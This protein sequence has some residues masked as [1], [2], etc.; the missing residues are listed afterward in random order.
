MAA[1]LP[2]RFEPF[3][4][5]APQRAL[6]SCP[7]RDTPAPAAT[8]HGILT[9]Y[10][11]ARASHIPERSSVVFASSTCS[12]KAGRAADPRGKDQVEGTKPHPRDRKGKRQGRG[13]GDG[14][15]HP[16]TWGCVPGQGD[17]VSSSPGKTA[18][19]LRASAIH[20]KERITVDRH[21][22]PDPGGSARVPA[23]PNQGAL[24]RAR[25]VM[26]GVVEEDRGRSS[27]TAPRR[28]MVMASAAFSTSAQ[29]RARG[30]ETEGDYALL[31]EGLVRVR[32]KR[33]ACWT[34][35]RERGHSGLRAQRLHQITHTSSVHGGGGGAQRGNVL[36]KNLGGCASAKGRLRGASPEDARWTRRWLRTSTSSARSAAE[37]HRDA[38]NELSTRSCC[39]EAHPGRRHE[40]SI[41]RAFREPLRGDSG[42][43]GAR[44]P[45]GAALRLTAGPVEPA[46]CRDGRPPPRQS[47]ARPRLAR[48]AAGEIVCGRLQ[49]IVAR[50][51]RA[52]PDGRA[53]R[54]PG[55]KHHRSGEPTSLSAAD[56]P[57]GGRELRWRTSP[58]RGAPPSLGGTGRTAALTTAFRGNGSRRRA[59]QRREAMARVTRCRL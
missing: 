43:S 59:D 24:Q 51:R 29:E 23:P 20:D 28:Q 21:P 25:L 32:G 57:R 17:R 37:R 41:V 56:Y 13:S 53:R 52:S 16:G 2:R 12:T 26:E 45:I 55:H 30:R 27:T 18:P 14:R 58:D 4:S 3:S 31:A 47:S 11:G 46:S 6:P 1:T 22:G 49:A 39:R 5:R 34:G 38:L 10:R 15:A 50:H 48:E 36:G 44:R 35:L 9:W 19:P 33:C 7:A 8:V 54:G 42:G 40:A